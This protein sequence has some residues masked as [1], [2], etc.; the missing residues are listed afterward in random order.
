[1]QAHDWTG[2]HDPRRSLRGTPSPKSGCFFL[3]SESARTLVI[4]LYS[5]YTCDCALWHTKIEREKQGDL[6]DPRDDGQGAVYIRQHCWK[7]KNLN[8][9]LSIMNVAP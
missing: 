3:L 4:W 8:S 7:V 6:R 9:D 5:R 2:S 1:M